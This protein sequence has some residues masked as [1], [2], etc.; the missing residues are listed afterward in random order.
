[1]KRELVEVLRCPGCAKKLSLTVLEITAEEV[2]TGT[3]ECDGCAA[4]Y[5][6][7]GGIPRFVPE[8]NYATNFG[9][10][11]NKFS[12]T[13]LDSYSGIDVSRKRFLASVG[14]AALDL[15][16]KLVLDVGCG[17]GRFAEIALSLGA[18]VIAV[19]YSSAVDA[20]F[21]NLGSNPRLSVIQGDIFH[22]PLAF[23][24]FELVYC[25]GVLQHTP[26]PGAAFAA[27]PR[28]VQPKGTLAVD[29]YPRM[30]SNLFWSKYWIRPLT[31]RIPQPLLF[32]LVEAATPFLLKVSEGLARV[33]GLRRRLRYLVPVVNYRGVIPL[34]DRQLREWAILDTFDMLAPA[35]DHPQTQETVEAWFRLAGLQEFEVT[36]IGH[37]I[38][39]GR[40]RGY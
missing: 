3:L 16:G 12:K 38:G 37:I 39:R 5:P 8:D 33:P 15:T 34:S 14:S 26:D 29:V 9:F 10:Q 2:V 35:H 23:D 18:T 28:L 19:D 36:R 20:C 4:R 13:Q 24:Q 21:H 25:L 17:A 31:R 32:R 22:L 6:I 40:K 27:L 11:W 30:F 7:I 1:M